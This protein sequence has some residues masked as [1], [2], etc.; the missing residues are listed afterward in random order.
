MCPVC[1]IDRCDEDVLSV[2]LRC[3]MVALLLFTFIFAKWRAFRKPRR[4]PA[5]HRRLCCGRFGVWRST[6]GLADT[7]LCCGVRA[8]R[9]TT[10]AHVPMAVFLP[11]A[12]SCSRCRLSP[13]PSSCI[14]R[15]SYLIT[16]LSRA[17]G[18]ADT[19]T[20]RPAP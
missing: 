17:A 7:G 1:G 5:G 13:A 14:S 15:A 16:I 9:S 18:D 12:G 2:S 3:G 11:A 4:A 6:G 8:P 19:H 20:P 10:C